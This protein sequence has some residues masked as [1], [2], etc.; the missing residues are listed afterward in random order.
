QSS[1]LCVP[2]RSA[3]CRERS[4]FHRRLW[5]SKPSFRRPASGSPPLASQIA[6]RARLGLQKTVLLA[7]VASNPELPV[8]T[9][10]L[11][12][13]LETSPPGSS[14]R[15]RSVLRDLPQQSLAHEVI[16]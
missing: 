3:S 14:N 15:I 2:L 4:A 1:L 16:L 13:V 7:L 12:S 10:M 5:K 9:R 6:S 8:A 11:S